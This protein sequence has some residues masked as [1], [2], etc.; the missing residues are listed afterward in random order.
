MGSVFIQQFITIF[1]KNAKLHLR[2]YA[3]LKQLLNLAFAVGLVILLVKL[4]SSGLIPLVMS[5][6]VMLL[7]RG[8]AFT[9]VEDRSEHHSK[10]QQAM[11]LSKM[12]YFAG[13]MV[14]YLLNCL[15]ISLILIGSLTVA[16]ALDDYSLSFGSFFA[17]Y[18]LYILNSFSFTLFL[19]N[20]VPDPYTSLQVITFPQLA[21]ICFY[22]LMVLNTFNNSNIS[23]QVVALLIPSAAFTYSAYTTKVDNSTNYINFSFSQGLITTAVSAALYFLLF[24]YLSVVLPN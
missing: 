11:G 6:S 19:T 1:I 5:L 14:F 24:L 15:C 21:G 13:W 3:F 2:S 4:Q 7:C 9:W 12:A 16:G 17:L 10:V 22:F 20:F 18:F 23:L 8:V